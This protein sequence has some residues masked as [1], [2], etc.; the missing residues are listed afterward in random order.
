MHA[1]DQSMS[2]RTAIRS[3]FLLL[4]CVFW[5]SNSGCQTWQQAFLTTELSQ[6]LCNIWFLWVKWKRLI[7]ISSDSVSTFLLNGHLSQGCYTSD[8]ISGSTHFS[9]SSLDFPTCYVRFIKQVEKLEFGFM[10]SVE[11]PL[12]SL[13]K[14]PTTYEG[15]SLTWMWLQNKVNRNN[16]HNLCSIIASRSWWE[17]K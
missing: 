17:N 3:G 6:G 12:V 14:S 16:F 2:Q 15:L 4:S 7:A 13:F 10:P 5:L 8:S 11:K 1:W 9:L